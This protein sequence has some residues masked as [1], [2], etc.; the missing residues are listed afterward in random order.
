MLLLLCD[1]ATVVKGQRCSSSPTCPAH[2]FGPRPAHKECFLKGYSHFWGFDTSPYYKFPFPSKGLYTFAKVQKD[3][4]DCCFGLEVQGFLCP[5][6]RGGST[7]RTLHAR[8]PGLCAPRTH[9]R[10]Y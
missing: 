5:I 10:T 2:V 4:S 7:V 9:V 1:S 6:L 3:T 8:K